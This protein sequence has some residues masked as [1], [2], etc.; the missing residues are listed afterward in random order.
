MQALW[1]TLRMTLQH[2][3]QPQSPDLYHGDHCTW[4]L[5]RGHVPVTDAKEMALPQ[6]HPESTRLHSSGRGVSRK[7]LSVYQGQEDTSFTT[8]MQRWMKGFVAKY[9]FD[10]SMEIGRQGLDKDDYWDTAVQWLCRGEQRCRV[11]LWVGSDPPPTMPLKCDGWDDLRPSDTLWVVWDHL[12]QV[13]DPQTQRLGYEYRTSHI[14]SHNQPEAKDGPTVLLLYLKGPHKYGSLL[15]VALSHVLVQQNGHRSVHELLHRLHVRLSPFRLQPVLECN[16]LIDPKE[17]YFGFD[18]FTRR[19]AD[20]SRVPHSPPPEPTTP[21]RK[22]DDG[23]DS[24]SN[25]SAT[26]P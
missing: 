11:L 19:S 12:G 20:P 14:V 22:P 10:H 2:L 9:A 25:A 17:L 24:P 1:A 16:R 21:R 13:A 4:C 6:L 3:T 18:Y 8:N 15:Q 7:W 23:L 5:N 26:Q